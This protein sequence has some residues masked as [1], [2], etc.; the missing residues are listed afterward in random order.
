MGVVYKL[1]PEIKE[2]ILKNKQK[3]P[4]LSCRK[5]ASLILEKFQ[6]KLS[7]STVNSLI[8][9]ANLSMPIGRRRKK[10]RAKL[11][12][13]LAEQSSGVILLKAADYLVR[14]SYYIA[15]A[16]KN[17]LNLTA[18]ELLTKTE[19][20]IYLP[21]FT[22]SAN[23]Q[24]RPE[25]ELWSLIN[26]RFTQ[27]E[28]SSYLLE[29]KEV[30]TLPLEIYRIISNIFQ[31]VRC[32]KVD[33]SG[34]HAFYLDGQLHTVWSTP[35]IPY[36]FSTTIYNIKG[37][38][39]KY[40]QEDS[41]FLLFMAPGYD[42]PT[43]EFFNFLLSLE[44]AGKD[45]QRLTLY[46]NKLEE[47]EVI[48]LA[49]AKKRFFVF[50]LWPWQFGAYRKVKAMG[51]YNPFYFEPLKENFYLAE[52][53]IELSQPN[54]NKRVTLQGFALKTSP[55]EKIR[56]VILSNLFSPQTVPEERANLYLAHWPN[57][58]EAFQDFSRKIELLTYT[59]TS[60]SFFSTENLNLN[61]EPLQGKDNLFQDYLAALDAY[62]RWHFLPSGYEEVDFA[63]T[64]ERF[65]ALPVEIKRQ[66]DLILVNFRPSAGY[67]FLKD[68]LYA[69]RRI[70]ERE[71]IFHQ[72]Q[73]LWLSVG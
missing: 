64:K 61:K 51:E 54:V 32:I 41:P 43:E 23:P 8:K 27:E 70:N 69:C 28:L 26:Q 7:K 20:L 67:G 33:V 65:Y 22:L 55:N 19:A 2:F 36:S 46:G 21:L 59:A 17:R 12:G 29:L 14:G 13:S 16:I 9:E 35:Q 72:G 39:N 4:N 38:I 53:E 25:E 44:A 73:R 71:V 56:V 47:I 60:Q 30:K 11:G 57:L 42:A 63:T 40:F 1:K 45:I 10:R 24:L 62:V 15:E 58:E 49:Q 5:L 31:E 52:T 66:K 68:L 50:G 34:G 18:P 3:E 48:N 6:L 37:Y